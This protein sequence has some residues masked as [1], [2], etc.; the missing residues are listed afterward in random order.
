M[1]L[2]DAVALKVIVYVHSIAIRAALLRRYVH[3]VVQPGGDARV[4]PLVAGKVFGGLP[5]NGVSLGA[6]GRGVPSLQLR[7]HRI[8]GRGRRLDAAR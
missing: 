4:Y 7:S 5:V 1:I 2:L 8:R 6:V 3:V